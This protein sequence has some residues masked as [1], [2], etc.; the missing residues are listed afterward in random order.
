[1][2]HKLDKKYT[3]AVTKHLAIP[4]VTPDTI[5]FVIS[6]PTMHRGSVRLFTGMVYTDKE[7]AR[8][9]KIAAKKLP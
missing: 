9:Q 8:L 5:K 7:Y 3:D 1:M 6:H 2:L 4:S